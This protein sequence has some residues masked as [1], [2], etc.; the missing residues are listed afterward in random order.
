VRL[1]FL[2][3]KL[4]LAFTLFGCLTQL[5]RTIV[6]HHFEVVFWTDY[7]CKLCGDVINNRFFEQAATIAIDTRFNGIHLC[8]GSGACNFRK[9]QLRLPLHIIH[10]RSVTGPVLALGD[11]SLLAGVGIGLLVFNDFLE[12]CHFLLH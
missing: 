7:A 11:L 4:F 1:F 5:L 3:Q 12:E 10:F 8:V 9:D 2:G 6:L